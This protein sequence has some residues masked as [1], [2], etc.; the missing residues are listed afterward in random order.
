MVLLILYLLFFLSG[1]ICLST[2]LIA[3]PPIESRTGPEQVH[4]LLKK[5]QGD[6]TEESGLRGLAKKLAALKES[7]GK[8][9]GK[10]TGKADEGSSS[11]GSSE[12]SAE[13]SGG[14]KTGSSDSTDASGAGGSVSFDGSESGSGVS[15]KGKST[16][17]GGATG[18]GSGEPESSGS[19][20]TSGSDLGKAEGTSPTKPITLKID[21]ENLTLSLAEGSPEQKKIENI[22]QFFIEKARE[23]KNR[24]FLQFTDEKLKDGQYK[25]LEVYRHDAFSALVQLAFLT[26]CFYCIYT[27]KTITNK[28]LQKLDATT[29]ATTVLFENEFEKLPIKQI[30]AFLPV[31]TSAVERRTAKQD[32]GGSEKSADYSEQIKQDIKTINDILASQLVDQNW[33]TMVHAFVKTLG[34]LYNSGDA[35]GE[36]ITQHE[37]RAA[38]Y[39]AIERAVREFQIAQVTIQ[40]ADKI[41]SHADVGIPTQKDTFQLRS[42]LDTPISWL[43]SWMWKE[44]ANADEASGTK[45]TAGSDEKTPLHEYAE[46]VN[47]RL[48]KYFNAAQDVLAAYDAA[49]DPEKNPRANKNKLFNLSNF[50]YYSFLLPHKQI[51]LSN[52]ENDNQKRSLF[53]MKCREWMAVAQAL[54]ADSKTFDSDNMAS[55]FNVERIQEEKDRFGNVTG[56]AFNTDSRMDLLE[57]KDDTGIEKIE[58]QIENFA[59]GQIDLFFSHADEQALMMIQEAAKV[60]NHV[61]RTAHDERTGG[62][63]LHM[64]VSRALYSS[65]NFL[66][67]TTTHPVIQ[68]LLK[69]TNLLQEKNK[70]DQTPLS[71]AL[72]NGLFWIFPSNEEKKLILEYRNNLQQTIFHILVQNRLLTSSV[73]EVIDTSISKTTPTQYEIQ[74]K[75]TF[76]QGLLVKDIDDLAKNNHESIKRCLVHKDARG[77]TPFHYAQEQKQPV[78]Y[79][80]LLEWYFAAGGSPKELITLNLPRYRQNTGDQAAVLFRQNLKARGLEEALQA[81]KASSRVDAGG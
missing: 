71:L 56:I 77:K 54:D 24:T 26:N 64:I 13:P 72:T 52:L 27:G 34:F 59:Q 33:L 42:L 51:S 14:G 62:N 61:L 15:G 67:P 12:P 46:D 3:E 78:V 28:A 73:P 41:A 10:V 68:G 5:L 50:L 38:L 1:P 37:A 31:L 70:F 45:T 17:G 43:S 65:P 36:K 80:L 39:E 75:K 21:T 69:D 47:N 63:I 19:I 79:N 7:L 76:K 20:D 55:V 57:M 44:S 58:K 81:Q 60:S 66:S 9:L 35:T 32:A 74:R 29:D 48:R 8:L 2:Q 18:E 53:V 49:C 23:I 4:E 11:S 6:D 16:D 25:E 30:V 22:I 40:F